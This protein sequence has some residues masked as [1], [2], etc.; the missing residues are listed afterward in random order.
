VRP[1]STN[2]GSSCSR[3]G[4]AFDSYSLPVGIRTVAVEGDALLLNGKPIH[5]R[6]FGRHEDF[7]VSGRGLAPAA[8]GFH[9]QLYDH[10]KGLDPSRPALVVS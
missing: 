7:P 8:K 9:R 1:A 2:C 4:E 3:S 10:A 5:L 6:G